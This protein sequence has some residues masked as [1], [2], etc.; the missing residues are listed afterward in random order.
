MSKI[1]IRKRNNQFE[2]LDL[3]K[4]HKV[5]TWAC[6]GINNVSVSELELKAELQFY[7]K[8]TSEEIQETL[9]KSAADL[10]TEE[11]P[12]YQYVASRLINFDLRKRAYGDFTIPSLKK[13]VERNVKLGYYE[14]DLLTWY[15][16]NDWEAMD[17][18]I[19]HERDYNIV[20]AGMEQFRRKYLVHNK[21]TGEYFETP[22][23]AYMLIAAVGF[24]AESK[25]ERIRFIKDMYNTVSNFDVSL[26]SPIVAGVRTSTKQFSSCVLIDVG[27]SLD[28]INAAASSIVKYASKRAGIGVNIGRIR[29]VNSP[30]RN[31]EVSH[32]GVLPFIKYLI[33]ALK[34]CNQGGL[35]SSS[36][37][38]YYPMWHYEYEDLIVLKNNK[39]TEE[40]R[41][42]AVDYGIQINKTLLQRLIDSKNLTLFSPSD[43]PGLYDAFFRSEEEFRTLY[44]KYEADP[45]VRKKTISAMDAFSQLVLE[46]KETGRIYVQFVDN[47]NELGPFNPEKAPVVMSNLCAEITEPTVPLEHV[48]DEKGEIAL[49]TL[50]AYNLG[51]MKQ[52]DDFERPA[53][54]LVRFLDNILSYQDYMIPAAKTSTDKYRNLGIGIINLAYFLAKHNQT[55][56][57]ESAP[58]FFHPFMEAMSYYTIKASVDLA[59]ERGACAGYENT[60]WAQGILPIDKYRKF[61]DTIAPNHLVLDWEELRKS[62]AEYGIRNATLMAQMP[63]ETSAML[64]NSTNGIEPPRAMVS[65]KNSKDGA[66]RQVVPEA[67]RLRKR[68]EFLWDQ[69]SPT[70]YLNLM[71][72]MNKFYCQSISTNTSYNPEF[73]EDNQI[74]MSVLLKDLIYTYQIGL[75]TLYYHNENDS[76]GEVNIAEEAPLDL[77]MET[78][79][80]EF[81]ESCAI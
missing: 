58:E 28:S 49:C 30:V 62:M 32:T 43:V 29:A 6:E 4:I 12:N 21:I 11:T 54:I 45:N 42:R 18:I 10:I 27:D 68:Y 19:R 65:V 52:P 3:E 74:P 81:C 37:T 51:N 67:Y 33:G 50:A 55:Y 23:V 41:A 80:D 13:I 9:I 25:R 17:R 56:T 72:V 71:A 31:G 26:P 53:R 66:L 40:N 47:T 57:S 16:D 64:T 14:A 59:K 20:F 15:D 76:A 46:R 61:V 78:E 48:F 36:A 22:Q 60:K 73:Y 44:E 7:D 38:F 2:N 8:M 34:S 70:G 75:R 24:H 5:V 69:K 77:L 79:E 63:A 35:R 39:G 1:T